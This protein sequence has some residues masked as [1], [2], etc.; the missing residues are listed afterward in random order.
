MRVPPRVFHRPALEE[1]DFVLRFQGFR[2]FRTE[3]SMAISLEAGDDDALLASLGSS[4]RR[5]V[6]KAL[7]ESLEHGE[8]DDVDQYWEILADNLE[9]RYGETPTHTAEELH[10]L[11]ELCPGEVRL[12]VARE[13]ERILGGTLV[14]LCNDQAAHAFY[15]ASREEAQDRRPLNLAVYSAMKWLRSNGWRR[16]NLGVSTPDGLTV[17]WGLVSFKESFNATGVCR[18]SY[19]LLFRDAGAV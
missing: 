15:L 14:V 18:E 8:S 10:R 7:K 17:N 19:E 5:A 16:L 11:R 1:L 3:L 2:I 4:C 9:R 6:R 12:F 13:G